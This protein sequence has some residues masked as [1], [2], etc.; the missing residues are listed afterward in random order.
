MYVRRRSRDGARVFWLFHGD[1]HFFESRQAGVST[2]TSVAPVGTPYLLL[3]ITS[4]RGQT[5]G[6]AMAAAV[7][8][9][10]DAA[11]Q[12]ALEAL[13]A[14]VRD[15]GVGAARAALEAEGVALL[16]H[17]LPQ[18][19]VD[20]CVAEANST[21]PGAFRS[22]SHHNAFL[23]PDDHPAVWTSRYDPP[24]HPTHF[25]PSLLE[26]TLRTSQLAP[27]NSRLAARGL[28]L[29][30]CGPRLAARGSRLAARGSRLAARGSRLA[31]R[32][33]RL[34]GILD[35]TSKICARPCHAA[36]A[37]ASTRVR[38]AKTC[39]T[40][41]MLDQATNPLVPPRSTARHVTDTHFDSSR[42]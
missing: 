29:M 36:A 18:H 15:I 1:H 17:V 33:S 22:S 12:A 21:A 8:A 31:A 16:K 19:F 24:H 37:A 39:I 14:N 3:V 40:G 7:L 11:H 27:H 25:E 23:V 34:A 20:A 10:G 35:A 26:P 13:D 9:A 4:T 41:D 38:S 5:P 6:Q 30:A 42:K 2:L 28:R 32:G